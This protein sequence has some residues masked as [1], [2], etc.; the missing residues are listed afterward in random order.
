MTC[1]TG[2]MPYAS[3]CVD[4]TS[5]DHD[6]SSSDQSPSSCF[7]AAL[8]WR[9]AEDAGK[10]TAPVLVTWPAEGATC[11]DT[12]PDILTTDGTWPRAATVDVQSLSSLS[13]N[14]YLVESKQST[15]QG[16]STRYATHTR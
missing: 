14:S 4:D 7:T 16:N 5:G 3:L 12:R 8:A 15:D 6:H 11:H 1:A 13:F 10:E 9:A 2:G